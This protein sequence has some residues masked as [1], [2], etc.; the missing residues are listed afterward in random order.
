MIDSL[1]P[2]TEKTQERVGVFGHLLMWVITALALIA[3]NKFDTGTPWPTAPAPP[4]DPFSYGKLVLVHI[5]SNGCHYY[6]GIRGSER[7]EVFCPPAK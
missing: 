7:R 4:K 3:W 1:P 5:D 2:P 6:T